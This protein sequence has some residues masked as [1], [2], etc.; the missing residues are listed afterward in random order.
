M[1]ITA[2]HWSMD[3]M[4][5]AVILF[6]VPVAM[7]PL[8]VWISQSSK[9]QG[10]VKFGRVVSLVG[11]L[12]VCASPWTVPSSPSTDAGHLLGS[13]IGPCMMMVIGM[14]LIAFSGNV[15]VGKLPQ[16]DRRL[17]FLLAAAGFSWL[18]GMHW[19]ILTPQLSP[20]VVNPYWYVFWPTFLLLTSCLAS[21][22]ATA[23]LL[24][25]DERKTE[26]S[27]MY[28][29]SG[30]SLLMMLVGLNLDGPEMSSEEFRIH[31]GLATADLLGILLGCLLSILAFASVIFLYER[32]LPK[33]QTVAPPSN[34]EL[35]FAASV[36]A[37]HIGGEEE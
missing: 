36:I 17:G 25:G 33:P 4:L 30:V 23:L 28:G 26:A 5:Q 2:Q 6:W 21:F 18:A 16:S 34:D 24:I 14:Y 7:L 32:S 9:R 8:G 29:L 13:I 3:P 19:W 12:M 31:L 15:P 35:E 1:N 10:Q 11:I 37:N 20:G 22:S 27:L